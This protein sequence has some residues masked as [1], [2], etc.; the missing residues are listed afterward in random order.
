MNKIKKFQKQTNRI[1]IKNK[2]NKKQV[3]KRV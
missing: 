2:I 1:Q 3:K